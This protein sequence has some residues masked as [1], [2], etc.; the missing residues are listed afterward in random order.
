LGEGDP[1]AHCLREG[2]EQELAGSRQNSSKKRGA[3][4]RCAKAVSRKREGQ[5]SEELSDMSL[6]KD[7]DDDSEQYE[8]E[9]PGVEVYMEQLKHGKK[10]KPIS[11]EEKRKLEQAKVVVAGA[12]F[13]DTIPHAPWP[14]RAMLKRRVVLGTPEIPVR[15]GVTRIIYPS[16]SMYEGEVT[17]GKRHGL[18]VYTWKEV[19][20]PAL[21][22]PR[23]CSTTLRYLPGQLRCASVCKKTWTSMHISMNMHTVCR[24]ACMHACLYTSSSQS[25]C[26]HRVTAGAFSWPT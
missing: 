4:T 15:N 9:K 16:G 7:W 18:G 10:K 14:S 12:E 13:L 21:L 20:S 19:W 22:L 11:E 1:V 23:T 24:H 6:F 3:G 5:V 17:D 8:V 2:G 25:I 26:D